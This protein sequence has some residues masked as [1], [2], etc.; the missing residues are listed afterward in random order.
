MDADIQ[1]RAP[2][3][4][5]PDIQLERDM[6]A[7]SLGLENEHSSPVGLAYIYLDEYGIV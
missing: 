1:Y 5:E 4:L 3:D 7:M 2:Q 6:K